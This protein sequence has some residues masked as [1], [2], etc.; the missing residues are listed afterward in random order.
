MYYIQYSA[1]PSA[2]V[3]FLFAEGRSAAPRLRRLTRRLFE[4]DAGP[5]AIALDKGE[6]RFLEGAAELIHIKPR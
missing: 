2:N 5:F 3:G 1:V 6:P 4:A